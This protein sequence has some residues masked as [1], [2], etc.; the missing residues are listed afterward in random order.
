MWQVELGWYCQTPG[1]S[2]RVKGI[3]QC[4]ANGCL[5]CKAAIRE[6]RASSCGNV[7]T[8]ESRK[9]LRR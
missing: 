4:E 1:K 5:C 9:E 2:D 3:A 8:K 7:F 6:E